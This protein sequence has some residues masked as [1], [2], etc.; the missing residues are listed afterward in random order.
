MIHYNKTKTFLQIIW[1]TGKEFRL[2]KKAV[3]IE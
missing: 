1:D 2:L 3:K